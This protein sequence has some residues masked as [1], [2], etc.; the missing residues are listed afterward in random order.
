M[1][2]SLLKLFPIIATIQ[3]Q[4]FFCDWQ[5]LYKQ[6]IIIHIELLIFFPEFPPFSTAGPVRVIRL[7]PNLE[8]HPC[9]AREARASQ[10]R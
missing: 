9:L 8:I 5:I 1:E 10:A 6:P 7:R 3:F 2:I 4:G